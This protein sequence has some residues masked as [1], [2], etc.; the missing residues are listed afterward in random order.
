MS[1][2]RL[3]SG[4]EPGLTVFWFKLYLYHVWTV[5]VCVKLWAFKISCGQFVSSHY[6]IVIQMCTREIHLHETLSSSLGLLYHK[7]LQEQQSGFTES[8]IFLF[9]ETFGDCSWIW[10]NLRWHHQWAGDPQV[11][12]NYMLLHLNEKVRR[13]SATNEKSF[14]FISFK[15]LESCRC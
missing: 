4:R 15:S 3:Q 5:S 7:V 8:M 13:T 12:L 6:V 14:Y 11:Q 10:F 1:G 9:K 2:A